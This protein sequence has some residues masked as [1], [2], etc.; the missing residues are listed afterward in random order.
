MEFDVFSHDDEQFS[1]DEAEAVRLAFEQLDESALGGACCLVTIYAGMKTPAS[2]SELIPNLADTMGE[3]ACDVYGGYAEGW[4]DRVAEKNK[5]LQRQFET[6][7]ANFLKSN[8][9]R[10]DFYMVDNVKQLQVRVFLNKGEYDGYL[11]EG[12]IDE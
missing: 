2:I 5:L 6:F 11:I 3:T 1:Y 12:E 7:V 8:A 9:L 4:A 10:P